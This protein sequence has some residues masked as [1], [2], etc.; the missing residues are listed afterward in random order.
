MHLRRGKRFKDIT[1][2]D[3]YLDCMN[4]SLIAVVLQICTGAFAFAKRND[5]A[6]QL[7]PDYLVCKQT[8]VFRILSVSEW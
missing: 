6:K 7:I 1:A 8:I 2:P 4:G 3:F 5:Q